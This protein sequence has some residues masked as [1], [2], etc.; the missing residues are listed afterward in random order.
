[1][2]WSI[3]LPPHPSLN[4][5]CV[6]RS[7][8]P[9]PT[10]T[11]FY[12]SC[13]FSPPLLLFGSSHHGL[14][15]FFWTVMDLQCSVGLYMHRFFFMFLVGGVLPAAT[16]PPLVHTCHLQLRHGHSSFCSFDRHQCFYFVQPLHTSLPSHPPLSPSL[17]SLP[18]C[19]L[20][21]VSPP[22]PP[23]PRPLSV[24]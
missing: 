23:L 19:S 5:F 2:V 10:L 20:S 14:C 13:F 15:F 6:R 16:S 24:Y 8:P 22:P 12:N 17:P 11:A 9:T 4:P 18:L 3:S 7:L 21:S 1:M